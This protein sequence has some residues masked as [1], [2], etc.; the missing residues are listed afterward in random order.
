[1]VLPDMVNKEASHDQGGELILAVQFW[2]CVM[3]VS[4]S[5]M[6]KCMSGRQYMRCP[7]W[8]DWAM[9]WVTHGSQHPT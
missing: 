1:M 8:L 7:L 6:A 9:V 4:L 2:E 3:L 5:T